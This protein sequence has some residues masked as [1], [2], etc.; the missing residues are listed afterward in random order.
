MRVDVLEDAGKSLNPFLDVGQIE[1]AF[2]MGMGYFTSE[3]VVHSPETG[4]VL[5]NS[6]LVRNIKQKYIAKQ[7]LNKNL[8]LPLESKISES[9]LL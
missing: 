1:G 4:A 3:E 8:A 7:F 5:T 9:F 6:S 2:V